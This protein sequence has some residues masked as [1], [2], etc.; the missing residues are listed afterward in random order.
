MSDVT[1]TNSP[2]DT[3]SET[4][5]TTL[6]FKAGRLQQEWKITRYAQKGAIASTHFEWR[7]V[8]EVPDV[9]AK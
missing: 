9:Q 3:R 7:D 5:T 6:R 4:P 1:Y 8:P 2:Y